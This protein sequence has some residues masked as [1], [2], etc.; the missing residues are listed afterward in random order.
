MPPWRDLEQVQ[1]F[2]TRDVEA[3]VAAIDGGTVL[4][5]T[6]GEER[7]GVVHVTNQQDVLTGTADASIALLVVTVAAEGLG[8][9]RRLLEAAEE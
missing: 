7:L 8:V 5:A 9:G 1:D 3:A 4:P 6:R 2:H